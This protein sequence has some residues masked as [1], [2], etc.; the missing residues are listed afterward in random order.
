MK[1]YVFALAMLCIAQSLSNIKV[2]FSPIGQ[3]PV[4]YDLEIALKEL[5]LTKDGQEAFKLENKKI[6][7]VC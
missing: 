2:I 7:P 3:D 6:N 5:K 1:M 4:E